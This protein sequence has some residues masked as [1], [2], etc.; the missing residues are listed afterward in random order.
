MTRETY[1]QGK[2]E[3]DAFLAA[4]SALGLPPGACVVIEDALKGV[5]AAHRAGCPCIA[6][7]NDYTRDNDFT[8]ATRVVE[9]LDCVTAE[10]IEGLVPVRMSDCARAAP[11]RE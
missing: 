5:L 2:P 10:L 7:P 4:A 3:P 9:N 1:A 6:V 8:L 11:M